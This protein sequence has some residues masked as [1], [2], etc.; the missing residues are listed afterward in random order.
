[1]TSECHDCAAKYKHLVLVALENIPKDEADWFLDRGG[2]T[3]TEGIRAWRER[4][5][6][7]LGEF[8]RLGIDGL[9]AEQINKALHKSQE[10]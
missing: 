2:P 3:Q 1:M 8:I 6:D 7:V 5:A 10:R 4:V 9:S